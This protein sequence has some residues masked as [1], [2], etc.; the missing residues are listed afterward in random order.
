[1][2]SEQR[3]QPR[4]HVLRRGKIVFRRGYGAIDCVLLDVSPEGARLRVGGWLGLPETFELR[5]DNGAVHEAR[6]RYRHL[7][8]IGVQ[9]AVPPTAA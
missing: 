2:S 9:F 7:D 8:E 1:M 6:V 4:A 3:A 5:I